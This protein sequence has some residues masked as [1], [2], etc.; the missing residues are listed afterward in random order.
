MSPSRLMLVGGP[1]ECPGFL[2]VLEQAVRA[3]LRLFQLR[4]PGA[5]WP[6]LESLL[7][8][9]E[10]C[11]ELELLVN[12]RCD[13]A[14]QLGAGLHLPEH[15]PLPA[16]WPLDRFWGRSVHDLERAR[17]TAQEGAKYLVLGTIYPTPSKPGHPGS[18]LHLV[19]TV[20]RAVP[21][22]VYAIGGIGAE[23]VGSV[24]AAGAYGVAVRR[25]IWDSP[26][27]ARAVERLIRAAE[28][29]GSLPHVQE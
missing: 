4:V 16:A 25:A 18:G 14:L 2:G 1:D 28:G 29:A 22:P 23:E 24:R 15:A 21:C 8:L 6:S 12:G 19:R 20:S 13:L 11:P 27:P 5:G 3:G 9:R 17:I 7:R 10:T 26:E